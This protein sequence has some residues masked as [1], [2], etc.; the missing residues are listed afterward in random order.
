VLHAQIEEKS[1]IV[2]AASM[3]KQQGWARI[4]RRFQ[5]L[6]DLGNEHLA[7]PVFKSSRSMTYLLDGRF[8][9]WDLTRPAI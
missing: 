8:D 2:H 5:A 4:V 9:H 6:F 1:A 3:K 7:E